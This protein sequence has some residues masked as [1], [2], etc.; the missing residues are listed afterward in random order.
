MALADHDDSRW[1]IVVVRMPVGAMTTAEF[2]RHLQ[3]LAGYLQRG[4]AH[5]LII[6][7]GES[8]LLGENRHQIAA[9]HRAHA[10]AVR[11]YL[12]GVAL[13]VSAPIHRAMYGAIDSLLGSPYPLRTFSSQEEAE[14]WATQIVAHRPS[15]RPRP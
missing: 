5:A 4:E 9:H 12:R 13:I 11:S 2:D 6:H 8:D 14:A 7:L 10:A 1:P 15:S 3:H